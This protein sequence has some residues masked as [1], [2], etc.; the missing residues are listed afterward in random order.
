MVYLGH[1]AS[2]GNITRW[3]KSRIGNPHRIRGKAALFWVWQIITKDLSGFSLIADTLSSLTRKYLPDKVVWTLTCQAFYRQLKES[4]N[5][6]A[7]SW[8]SWP[9]RAFL[10]C[11]RHLKLRHGAVLMGRNLT[12]L[13]Y[14]SRKLIPWE[15]NLSAVHKL[16]L[17]IVWTHD[18]LRLYL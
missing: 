5:F 16:C 17:A 2:T 3:R 9:W 12:S 11:K 14:L 10:C 13:L 1:R 8:S 15:R 4:C 6:P 7:C 18:W